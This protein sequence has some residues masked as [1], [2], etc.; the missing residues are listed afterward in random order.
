MPMDKFREIIRLQELGRNQTE[1]AN[2]CKVARSTVQDYL[3]RA[4]AKSLSYALLSQMSD[5]EAQALLGKGKRKTTASPEVIAYSDVHQEL[6]KKGVTLA[7]LWQEGLDAGEWSCSYGNFCRRY[8]QWKGRHNL[9]MRQIHKPGDKLFVDYS[10]LTVPI[11]DLATGEVATAEIFVACFGASNYTYAEATPSQALSHWIGSHQRALAFYGGVPAAIVPDNLKSGVTAPCRY[12]PGINRSYHDFAEHYGVAVIP[13]RVR[14]PRDKAKVEKAVQE[15][16]RQILA[17]LRH[18]QFTNF[19]DLNEAIR[20]YLGKLNNRTM[21]D[22]G[23]SR[24]A[25][26]QRT[27]QPELKPLPAYPFVFA[28]W[29]SARVNVDYHIEV[30]KHYYSVPYWFARKEV[31]IKVSEQLVEVFYDHGRIAVH[32]RS[33]AQYRHSTLPDHMPPEHWAYKQQSK[34]R[35]IAWAEQ[36]GEHTKTQVSAIFD[37]KAHEEQAFRSI[38]GLQRLA[39]KHG[40]QRLEFACRRAN[41]FGMTGLRRLKA[42]LK[43]HLDEVPMVTEES[44]APA[45]DHDNLRGQKYYS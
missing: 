8:N 24:L 28:T 14:K 10:G 25:L 2:S 17:R 9:S 29:K 39:T 27:D 22:Y 13:A 44:D 1:I 18:R 45:I 20:E 42:I 12:E 6:A 37:K 16:E 15:V 30:A 41:A 26:F 33:T 36:I 34:E 21:K 3:R 4:T 23:L 40:A 38:K 7:L 19:T 43:S 35:F 31:S 32:P 5:S 11:T